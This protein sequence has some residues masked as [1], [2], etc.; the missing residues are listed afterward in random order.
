M[1]PWL[2]A[3]LFQKE[4]RAT[5]FAIIRLTNLFPIFAN[6]EYKKELIDE[7]KK[8]DL[9]GTLQIF[10]KDKIPGL[11]GLPVKLFLICFNFI[12]DDLR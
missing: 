2:L 9:L 11:D 1:D 12:E 5:I 10:Q 8:E 7:V 3:S 4:F 6:H